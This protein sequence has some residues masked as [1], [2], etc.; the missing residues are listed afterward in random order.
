MNASGKCLIFFEDRV[1]LGF[2]HDLLE[3]ALEL[4]GSSFLNHLSYLRYTGCVVSVGT[5][6]CIAESEISIQWLLMVGPSLVSSGGRSSDAPSA[7]SC[8]RGW[9]PLN[10]PRFEE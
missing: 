5:D 7:R 1:R 8:E 2:V 9:L 6:V 4:W 10:N 3:L